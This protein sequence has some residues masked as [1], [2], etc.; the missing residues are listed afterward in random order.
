VSKP[1]AKV[2]RVRIQWVHLRTVLKAGEGGPGVTWMVRVL[3]R[4]GVRARSGASPFVGHARLYVEHGRVVK[5]RQVLGM[6]R[7]E[8]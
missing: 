6:K 4:A 8:R 1:R 3:K 7:G 5:S 2:K